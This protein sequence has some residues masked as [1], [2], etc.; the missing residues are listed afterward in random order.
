[1]VIRDRE[2]NEHVQG[3]LTRASKGKI[4]NMSL[5]G[6]TNKYLVMIL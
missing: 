1:M 4:T 2:D 6:K 3:I 5:N